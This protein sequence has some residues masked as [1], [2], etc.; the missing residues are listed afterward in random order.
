MRQHFLTDLPDS[1]K[2]NRRP[3]IGRFYQFVFYISIYL[4]HTN[5]K[6]KVGNIQF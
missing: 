6:V 5:L 3:F 2:D 4:H 1:V